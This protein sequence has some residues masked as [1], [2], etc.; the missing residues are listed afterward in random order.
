M[1]NSTDKPL[2]I[3]LIGVG[4]QGKKHLEALF[5]LE[6]ENI[7]NIVAICDT[8]AGAAIKGVPFFT[9]YKELLLS[10]ELDIVIIATPNYLHEKISIEALNR[11]INIIKE[12]PLALTYRDGKKIINLA[13]KHNLFI[14]TLQQRKYNPLFLKA[15]EEIDKLCSP[16]FFSYTFT[17][18]DNK[19]SWYWDIEAAGGGCW[20]NMGWHTITVLQWLIGTID[21]IKLK[22][23][24]GGKRPWDYKTDHS[25]TAAIIINK[26]NG[27]VHVSCIEPKSEEIIVNYKNGRL[28]LNRKKLVL[29][30]NDIEKSY[31]TDISEKELYY[32]QLKSTIEKILN[33]TYNMDDD[34]QT[35]KVIINGINSISL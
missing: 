1:L 19:N 8:N 25:A 28:L 24:I 16:L 14:A 11:K 18:D 21:H 30:I 9:N 6:K 23:E 22:W 17:I 13:K 5:E 15:K 12:K 33:K 2:R 31:E 35:L 27:T 3:G 29:R 34:L 7:V 32:L 4:N 20:I 26:L 10:T